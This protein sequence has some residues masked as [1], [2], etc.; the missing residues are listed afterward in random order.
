MAII[1]TKSI[2]CLPPSVKDF[3]VN[4]FIVTY[5]FT[6]LIILK[7]LMILDGITTIIVFTISYDQYKSKSN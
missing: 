5:N 2:V 3:S 4:T 1:P 6:Y 7:H